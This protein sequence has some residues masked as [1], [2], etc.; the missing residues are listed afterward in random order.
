MGSFSPFTF[1]VTIERYEFSAIIIPIQSLFCGLFLLDSSF[2][3]RVPL[4]IPC[5]SGLL[6]TYSFIFCLSW[7]LFMSPSILNES[8]AGY[9]ILGYMYFSFRT[10]NISC[11]PFLPC[12]FSL[13]K[14]AVMLIFSLQ[15]LEISFLLLFN[16]LLFICGIYNFHY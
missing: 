6:V 13:K 5:R 12:Q 15:N 16:G 11:Q 2:F 14:S 7:K 10:L 8:L 1:R 4:N 3:Y 9:S